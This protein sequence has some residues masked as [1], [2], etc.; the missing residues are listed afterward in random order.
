[1]SDYD[2]EKWVQSYRSAFMELEHAKMTGRVGDAR[3]EI[4]A[5]LQKLKEISSLHTEE[6]QAIEDALNGLRVLER[7]EADHISDICCNHS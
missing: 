7:E 3:H 5:R 4:A 2:K 6:S 1:M